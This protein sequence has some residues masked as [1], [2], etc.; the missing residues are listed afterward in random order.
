M[1]GEEEWIPDEKS[2]PDAP[3]PR[4]ES[5]SEIER[6]LRALQMSHA[7]QYAK[8]IQPQ[9]VEKYEEYVRTKVRPIMATGNR[10]GQARSAF[11]EIAAKATQ[12]R[13]ICKLLES[14][15]LS[16]RASSKWR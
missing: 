12:D 2:E 9:Q 5:I 11:A 15:N 10:P 7:E 1:A 16:T 3:R 6:R 13:K 4:E 8:D 14:E